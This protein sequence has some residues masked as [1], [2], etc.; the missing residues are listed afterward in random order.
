MP[1][2]TT[3]RIREMKAKG[4]KIAVLTATDWCWAGLVDKAGLDM[5][6]V[7]DSL[8]MVALGY[9][10]TLP[11]TMEEM[12]HHTRAVARGCEHALV[13]GDM[14]FMSCQESVAQAVHNAGRFLKEAGAQAVKVEGGHA[15]VPAVRRM[16]QSGIPVMGHVG[17]TPQH[18]HKLGGYKVQ[19]RSSQDS[20]RIL[21]EVLA[22]EEAGV[23]CVVLEC[24]PLD[25]AETV[26]REA[27]I[28]TIGIGAGPS[29]NGQVL[30]LHDV[31]GMFERFTPRFVKQYASLGEEA[32][33][34]LAEYVQEVRT[35]RF[36]GPEHSFGSGTPEQ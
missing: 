5:I 24:V 29:C 20:R 27:S 33:R 4:E 25:L 28:P 12:L 14:P 23:F 11:V 19:G 34:A 22:L 26:T 13:V 2:V 21:E 32:S 7:G 16:V 3:T 6:L 1:R 35:Q 8:G 10:N 17:L 31:L 15:V 18:V 9:E 36:P 30:V